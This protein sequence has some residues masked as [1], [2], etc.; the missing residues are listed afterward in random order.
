VDRGINGDL[1]ERGLIVL[2]CDVVSMILSGWEGHVRQVS[3]ESSPISRNLPDFPNLPTCPPKLPK[4]RRWNLP[5][6]PSLPHLPYLPNLL[7]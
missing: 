7:I 1:R 5:Y 3:K 4:E 2:L 6:L